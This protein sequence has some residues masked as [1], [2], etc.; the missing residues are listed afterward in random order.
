MLNKTILLILFLTVNLLCFGQKVDTVFLNPM[1]IILSPKHII[2][3][4]DNELEWGKQA[5]ESIVLTGLNNAEKAKKIESFVHQKFKYKIRDPKTIHEILEING[6]NCLSHTIMGIYLLRLAGIPAKLCYEFQLRKPLF[7]DQIRAKS[8]KTGIFGSGYNTHVW[9]MFYD[10]SKWQPYDSAL[11]ITGFTEFFS[12]RTAMKDT[13]ISFNPKTITGPPFLIL[14]E[15][16]TGYTKM[17][18]ITSQVW[19]RD[20]EWNNKKVSRKTWI[21]FIEQF[22]NKDY[23]YFEKPLEK[24]E[25]NKI[26][27]LSQ[28]WFRYK[29]IYPVLTIILFVILILLLILKISKRKRC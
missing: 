4:N 7:V 10:G 17:E 8:Q 29:T 13:W 16:G 20:F 19:N 26:K 28:E 21:N 24:T 6:G 12:I 15:T 25:Y 11:G 1:Q 3:I 2:G 18:N 14:Q 5:L 23:E 22:Y 27:K 9:V